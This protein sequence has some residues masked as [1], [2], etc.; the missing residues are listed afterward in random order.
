M[1]SKTKAAGCK[2]N[3][4]VKVRSKENKTF[5]NTQRSECIIALYK[6]V[7]KS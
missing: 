6:C 7:G 2:A 1:R 5:T 4:N 3:V